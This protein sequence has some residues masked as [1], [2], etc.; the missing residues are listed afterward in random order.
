MLGISGTSQDPINYGPPGLSFT[1]FSALSD[2]APN[3]G[4]SQTASF[5]DSFTYVLKRKHNLTFGFS[6]NRLRPSSQNYQNARGSFSFSGLAT[7]KL[8]AAGQPVKGTGFD[9]AD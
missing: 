4:T 7:S 2:G 1:N 6:Y 8:D 9:F 3:V 5:T